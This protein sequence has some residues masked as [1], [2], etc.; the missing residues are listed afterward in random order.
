MSQCDK[1]VVPLISGVPFHVTVSSD[2]LIL[3]ISASVNYLV[4]ASDFEEI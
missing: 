3:I 4:S 1:Y 2:R